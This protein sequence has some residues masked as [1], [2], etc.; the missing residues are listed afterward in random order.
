MRSDR[1]A[2]V[3]NSFA[4]S[5]VTE[6]ASEKEK[7][8]KKKERKK[9]R[10]RRKNMGEERERKKHTQRE[11]TESVTAILRVCECVSECMCV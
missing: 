8:G 10:E 6:K 4:I 1:G 5:T 9:Q 7:K 2:V 3:L 11:P